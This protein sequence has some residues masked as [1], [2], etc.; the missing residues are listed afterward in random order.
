MDTNNRIQNRQPDAKPVSPLAETTAAR[1]PSTR[2]PVINVY[3]KAN[4]EEKL[5]SHVHAR[6]GIALVEVEDL[7]EQI[8]HA[9][10]AELPALTNELVNSLVRLPGKD[11]AAGF[12]ACA[13]LVRLSMAAASHR[14]GIMP[15]FCILTGLFQALPEAEKDKAFDKLMML[16]SGQSTLAGSR[17]SPETRVIGQAMMDAMA[18]L[19]DSAA[20][21][22]RHQSQIEASLPEWTVSVQAVH[23]HSDKA[24]HAYFQTSEKQHAQKFQAA[25]LAM[26]P[27]KFLEES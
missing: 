8:R 4:A 23:I 15:L 9:A 14:E 18:K 3:S 2:T 21:G 22:S 1:Q 13:D 25:L 27:S 10:A 7:T 5:L 19:K 17:Y 16:M 6:D 12:H 20:L 24:E 26:L 11:L